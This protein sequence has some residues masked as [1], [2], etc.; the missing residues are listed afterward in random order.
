MACEVLGVD[1]AVIKPEW[2]PPQ[3]VVKKAPLG[4]AVRKAQLG[5]G[6]VADESRP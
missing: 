6:R 1:E 5:R 3:Q 2:E 4:Q